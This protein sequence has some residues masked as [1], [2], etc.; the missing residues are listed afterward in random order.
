MEI[1]GKRASEVDKK[2]NIL[3]VEMV[4]ANETE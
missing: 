1:G 3:L 4:S 2:E